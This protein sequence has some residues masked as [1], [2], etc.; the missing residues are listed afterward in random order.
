ME[1][2]TVTVSW[3]QFGVQI[4]IGVHIQ[5]SSNVGLKA[6]AASESYAA[7]TL[8]FDYGS[9]A[10]LSYALVLVIQLLLNSV[11][12]VV[13]Y[14]SAKIDQSICQAMVLNDLPYRVFFERLSESFEHLE[15]VPVAKGRHIEILRKKLTQLVSSRS[16][17]EIQQDNLR[18]IL[19]KF[20]G[21]EGED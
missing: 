6:L 21:Q 12:T 18:A 7:E 8:P 14:D 15:F 20:V 3:Q 1:Q 11:K 10:S 17:N 9:I 13:Y 2:V 16:T 19:N 5:V 4:L